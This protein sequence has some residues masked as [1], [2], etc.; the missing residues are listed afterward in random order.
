MRN[1]IVHQYDAVDLDIVWRTATV[2]I[3]QFRQTL[4]TIIG[5]E[6]GD[7]QTE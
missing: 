6:T 4:E 5:V 2:S 7:D 1:I 3:P